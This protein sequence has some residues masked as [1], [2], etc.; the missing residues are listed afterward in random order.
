VVRGWGGNEVQCHSKINP[1]LLLAPLLQKLSEQITLPMMGIRKIIALI[2]PQ[3][4]S[5]ILPNHIGNI[6]KKPGTNPFSKLTT[7]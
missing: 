5:K 2:P 6:A 1:A 3:K 4:L 7:V